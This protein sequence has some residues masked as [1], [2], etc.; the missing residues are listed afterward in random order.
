MA[1][2]HGPC[3]LGQKLLVKKGSPFGTCVCECVVDGIQSGSLEWNKLK[4]SRYVSCDGYGENANPFGQVFDKETNTCYEK[5]TQVKYTLFKSFTF[6]NL[7]KFITTIYC[8]L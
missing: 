6:W 1:G 7:N 5:A 2:H 3:P 8:I 4:Y